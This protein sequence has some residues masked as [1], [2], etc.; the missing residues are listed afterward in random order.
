MKRIEAIIKPFK[1]EEVRSVLT[2]LGINHITIS[3]VS[4]C[5]RRNGLSQRHYNREYSLDF[6]PKIKMEVLVADALSGV[7]SAAIVEAARTGTSG[8]GSILIS[9]VEEAFLI[10]AP[11]NERVGET[12]GIKPRKFEKIPVPA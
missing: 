9:Q 2:E 4:S 3:D 5:E 10:H 1:L 8:D 11:D 7:V 6:S 12:Q